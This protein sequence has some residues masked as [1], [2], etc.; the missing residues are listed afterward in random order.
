MTAGWPTGVLD[1]LGRRFVPRGLDD[2]LTRLAAEFPGYDFG[3]QR[4]WSGV[5][6]VALCRDGGG[7]AGTYAV[8]TSDA[9]EMRDVLASEADSVSYVGGREPC[10]R[11]TAEGKS[12]P[13][14]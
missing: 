5:S 8:I 13:V 1:A 9:D 4:T 14:S 3:T 12:W 7:R 10:Q 6:L 2:V 11:E